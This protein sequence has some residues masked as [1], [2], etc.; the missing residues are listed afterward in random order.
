MTRRRRRRGR[1][2]A[3]TRC[4]RSSTR[5]AAPP[6]TPTTT[7]A[8]SRPRRRRKAPRRLSTYFDNGWLKTLVEPRGNAIGATAS[9]YTWTYAYDAAGNRTSA[10]H[11]DGGTTTSTYDALNRLTET[12]DPLS[13]HWLRDYDDA[14]NLVYTKD[15]LNQERTYTYD[16]ENRV[17]SETDERGKTTDFGYDEDGNRTSLVAPDGATTSWTYTHDNRLETMV[18][19]RGNASGATPADFTWTYATDAAGNLTEVADPLGNDTDATYDRVGNKLTETDPNNHTTS[20]HYDSLNRLDQVTGPDGGVTSY[21]YDAAGNLTS[22]TDDNTHQTQY[23]YDDDNR[24]E[25]ITDPATRVWNYHYDE[26]GNRTVVETAAGT[27]TLTAGDGTITASYDRMNRPTVLDYSDATPDIGYGYDAAGRRTSM[28]DSGGSVTFGYDNANHLTGITRGS[29]TTSFGYDD[30]GNVDAITYPDTTSVTKTY[31]D[32]ERLET[33]VQA[34]GTTT[35]TYDEASNLATVTGV[36]G[37][38]QTNTVDE[39]GRLAGV[40][41]TNGATTISDYARTLD[42][43]GNPTQLAITRGVTTSTETYQYDDN[44]RLTKVCY[45]AS[46]SGTPNSIAYTYDKI[47]NRQ[48]DVRTGVANPG[49]TSY[50]YD[51][52]DQL[53][54]TTKSGTPTTYSYDAN[55]NQTAAGATTYSYDLANHLTSSTIGGVTTNYA[56]D[57]D[58]L[59][60]ATTAAG[61]TT[62]LYWDP[63]SGISQPLLER[64]TGGTL[65]RRYTHGSSPLTIT[66]SAGSYAYHVDP[67]GSIADVTDTTGAVKLS[68][69]YEPFGADIQTAAGGAPTNPLRFTAGYRD[70][71]TG[72]YSLHARQYDPTT[73]RFHST[74]P[75]A[76]A[77]DDP[78]VANYIYVNNQPLILVDPTGQGWGDV[79]DAVGGA[80]GGLKDAAATGVDASVGAAQAVGTY[81]VEHPRET[82]VYGAAAISLAAGQPGLAFLIIDA[83]ATYE[84]VR[85]DGLGAGAVTAAASIVPIPGAGKLA[86]FCPKLLAKILGRGATRAVPHGLQDASDAAF[87]ASKGPINIS[88]K[89]Y[90][91][92]GVLTAN[93]GRVSILTRPSAKRCDRPPRCSDLT[94]TPLVISSPAIVSTQTWDEPLERVAKR[95]FEQSCL[96]TAES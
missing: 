26:N 64:T 32:N 40:A 88:R 24:L 18:E 4:T 44:D 82:V 25:Q 87:K 57:G 28:T 74:D 67:L 43:A 52:A 37:S 95:A 3:T 69:T 91:D 92:A 77:I 70:P 53:T 19:A 23:L 29:A 34:A 12:V 16:G 61:T 80:A 10:A 5:T 78:Y 54:S 41:N 86:R 21:G 81:V 7:P 30:A 1:T 13:H 46:C 73:G 83:N 31:D 56:Y 6:P 20:Y 72:T 17:T 90:P 42:P 22:R 66:T 55:G 15:P 14:G 93:L 8:T 75:L 47:G 63:T 45:A 62:N 79:V 76:P 89:H 35:Y 38:V 85:E 58:G 11:P 48:T 9:D 51:A 36:D 68:Y 27:A 2:T 33:V 49:T 50:A 71:D 84:A 59:R 60:R 96:R 39:A 94:G 65:V